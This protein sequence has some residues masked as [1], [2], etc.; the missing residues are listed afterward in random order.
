MGIAKKNSII[1]VDYTNQL[2]ER[3]ECGDAASA[4]LK[5]GPIRLRPI[6]MTSGATAIAAVPLALALGPGGELRM[7]MA[8]AVIGGVIASTLLSLVVVPAVYVLADKLLSALG[9][10]PSVP[11]DAAAI[12]QPGEHAHR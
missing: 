1:L 2:R 9:R 6:L 7:P 3:G 10:K 4:V 12:D 5:A 8:I 11:P